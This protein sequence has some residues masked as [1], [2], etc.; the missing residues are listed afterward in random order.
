M[1]RLV[2]LARSWCHLC[3]DM[4]EA[5]RPVAA[6]LGEIFE[7]LD[8]DAHEDLVAEWDELVPV[9]LADG[10]HVCHYHFDEA[11]LRAYFAAFPVKSPA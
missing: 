8:V 9:L 5:L 1:A 2:I 7:V 11:A 3:D 4:V 10:R 6:E